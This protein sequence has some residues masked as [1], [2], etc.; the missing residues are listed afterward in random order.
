V[1]P[2]SPNADDAIS[3]LVL[4]NTEFSLTRFFVKTKLH[5]LRGATYQIP[6]AELLWQGDFLGEK[7]RSAEQRNTAND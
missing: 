4:T 5:R 3:I 1:V 2:P 7:R 6:V